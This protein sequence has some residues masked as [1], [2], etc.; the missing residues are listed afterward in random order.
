M[1]GEMG[2]VIQM[3]ANN[4]SAQRRQ[5][6]E[7]ATVGTQGTKQR[8]YADD[9]YYGGGGRYQSTTYPRASTG[10]KRQNHAGRDAAIGGFAGS[11]VK[12][13]LPSEAGEKAS[14]AVG[15]ITAEFLGGLALLFLTVFTDSTSS[16]SDKMLA[17]MKRGTLLGLS[18]FLLALISG[19]GPNAARVAKAFGLLLDVGILMSL[20]SDTMLSELDAF[21]TGTWKGTDGTSSSAN[22]QA[23]SSSVIGQSTGSVGSDIANADIGGVTISGISAGAKQAINAAIGAINPL[24]NPGELAKG[25]DALKKLFG[26]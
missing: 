13:Y 12:K 15:A 14:N 18:F 10:S 1:T 25:I 17:I 22:A 24:S 19:Q 2:K 5:R 26:G 3:P 4:N 21:F 8:A 9:P 11:D 7:R 23:G 16:Y 20:A 6:I